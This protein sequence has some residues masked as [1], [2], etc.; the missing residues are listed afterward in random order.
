MSLIKIEKF[1][2]YISNEVYTTKCSPCRT[3]DCYEIEFITI[4]NHKSVINGKEYPQEYGNIL[5]SAPGDT[6]YTIGSF[7]CFY[8]HFKSNSEEIKKAFGKFPKVFKVIEEDKLYS[9]FKSMMDIR[10]THNGY[11]F[12][13]NALLFGILAYLSDSTAMIGT[14]Q[15][16]AQYAQNIFLARKFI[17]ENYGKRIVL[18]DI[19]KSANLSKG[20]FHKVFKSMLRCTPSE[21]LLKIRLQNA[22]NLLVNSGKS[23]IDVSLAC[24]FESQ[25][26]FCS[27]FKKYLG[28]TPKNYRNIK[29]PLL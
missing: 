28:A 4:A 1:G 5:T 10:A 16:Y 2:Y 9:L 17:E 12:R 3:V 29:R 22:E 7:E 23:I 18:D 19:A 24:G 26:Y 14:N 20:F 25:S 15:Q 13:I 27:V 6:R 11:E 21:Y 8:I